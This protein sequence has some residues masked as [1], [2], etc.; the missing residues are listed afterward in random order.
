MNPF[1]AT[2]AEWQDECAK[3]GVCILNSRQKWPTDVEVELKKKQ[4]ENY[5]KWLDEKENERRRKQK[6]L[7][8]FIASLT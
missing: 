3:H 2:F 8:Q 7:K 5:R 6:E 4:Q 1:T